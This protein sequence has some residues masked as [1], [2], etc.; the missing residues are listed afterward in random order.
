ME[1]HE[2]GRNLA[3][4]LDLLFGYTSSER[5]ITRGYTEVSRAYAYAICVYSL[6]FNNGRTRETQIN[7]IQKTLQNP[8]YP[9]FFRQHEHETVKQGIQK[10]CNFLESELRA[11]KY[12][13]INVNAT[14]MSGMVPQVFSLLAVQYDVEGCLISS[15]ESSEWAEIRDSEFGTIMN[16]NINQHITFESD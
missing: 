11:R 16:A 8:K 5:S 2:F 4:M 10:F 12:S 13:G 6:H 1:V 14:N 3:K 15:N 9:E 7:F